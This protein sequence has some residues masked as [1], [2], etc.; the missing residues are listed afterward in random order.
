MVSHAEEKMENNAILRSS[1]KKKNEQVEQKP[2]E[3]DVN[4]IGLQN[5]EPSGKK[6]GKYKRRKKGT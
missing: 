3:S 2:N 4:E 6:E 5:E 1:T